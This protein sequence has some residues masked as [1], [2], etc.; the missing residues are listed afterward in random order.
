MKVQTLS[1]KITCLFL[2]NFLLFVHGNSSKIVCKPNT[3]LSCDWDAH[4]TK[5][6]F[7][8]SWMAAVGNMPSSLLPTIVGSYPSHA[9]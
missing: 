5:T 6:N 8:S 4:L 1:I 9:L 2:L 3:T 7:S